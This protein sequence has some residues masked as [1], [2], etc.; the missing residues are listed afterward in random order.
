M[1]ELKQGILEMR[2]ESLKNLEELAKIISKEDILDVFLFMLHISTWVLQE[3]S[4][5]QIIISIPRVLWEKLNEDPNWREVLV[6]NNVQEL[7]NYIKEKD[8]AKVF[9]QALKS[10]SGAAQ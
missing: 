5:D 6:A 3:Q 2:G 4:S 10:Q 7:L 1:E 8:K 9:F